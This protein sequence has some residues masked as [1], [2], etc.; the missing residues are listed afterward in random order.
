MK[1]C[2]THYHACDC[3]EEMLRV[4]C[5]QLLKD[6]SQRPEM[7]GLDTLVQDWAC[8][9]HA[10]RCARTLIGAKKK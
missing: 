3:R 6:H 1:R 8:Q 5:K 9:C 4:V 7:A 10:C 2:T